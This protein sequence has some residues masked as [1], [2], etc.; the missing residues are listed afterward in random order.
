[1]P[2]SLVANPEFITPPSGPFVFNPLPQVPL[3]TD[4]VRMAPNPI[5]FEVINPAMI[6]TV[7]ATGGCPFP[8]LPELITSVTLTPGNK[9]RKGCSILAMTETAKEVVIDIPEFS[10]GFSTPFMQYGSMTYA[11]GVPTAVLPV[12]L[13]GYYTEKYWYDNEYI[14]A[15][16]YQEER[17]PTTVNTL[18][19]V[20][21]L[22]GERT[23]PFSTIDR[24][25]PQIGKDDFLAAPAKPITFD[26][27]A[28][29]EPAATLTYGTDY[30]QQFIPRISSWVKWKPSEIKKMTYYYTLTVTHTCPPFVTY[31]YGSMVVENNWTPNANRLAYYIDKTVGFLPP[32]EDGT[33]PTT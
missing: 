2:V 4:M 22:F 9:Q 10:A 26:Q 24:N 11:P 25:K 19:L 13:K 6:L 8:A 30:L 20:D 29:T 3:Y 17:P 1:M 12:P 14:F 27:L 23:I 5:L 28:V 31:F 18:T 16:Y 21:L 7:Q 32:P 33:S 15:T